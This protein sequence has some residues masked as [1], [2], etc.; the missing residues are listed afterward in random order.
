M[1]KGSFIGEVGWQLPRYVLFDVIDV[2]IK[3]NSRFEPR[4][5]RH[6]DPSLAATTATLR[7]SR[8]PTDPDDTGRPRLSPCI[9][10]LKQRHRHK[11]TKMRHLAAYLALILPLFNP[12]SGGGECGTTLYECWIR[13][14]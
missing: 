7:H 5:S 10:W 11:I 2:A 6:C 3:E 1:A 13:N 12:V 4:I 9:E 14:D 8:Q